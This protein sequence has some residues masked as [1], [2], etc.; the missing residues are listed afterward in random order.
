MKMRR[1]VTSSF[2]IPKIIG[3]LYFE[4]ITKIIN[5]LILF[6]VMPEMMYCQHFVVVSCDAQRHLIALT[7]VI[8]RVYKLKKYK[9]DKFIRVEGEKS[10]WAAIDMSKFFF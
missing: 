10:P 3:L 6:Q 7:E 2:A 8:K 5:Q 4:L 1:K 9:K